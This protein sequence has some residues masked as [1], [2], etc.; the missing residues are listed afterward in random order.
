MPAGLVELL[1]QR[2]VE[3]GDTYAAYLVTER[4][5]EYFWGAG[6]RGVVGFRRRGRF[7]TVADGLLAAPDDR[8]ALLAEFLAF[9]ALNRWHTSYLNVPRNE[10]NLFR[11]QGCEVT[12]CGE[13]PLVRL[14][15]TRWQGKDWEWVRRQESY[16]KRHGVEI[17]EVVPDPHDHAYR[18]ASPRSSTRS[19]AT[20]SPTRSTAES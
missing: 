13:E 10:I 18:T 4:D 6:R 9:A 17:R 8:E 5:R 12:K 16:C 7:V 11:R 2:A 15:R 1:R 14:Q 20:T 19:R 3:L